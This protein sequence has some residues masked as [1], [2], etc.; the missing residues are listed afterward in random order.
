MLL[1]DTDD[2]PEVRLAVAKT[3][4]K[5]ISDELKQLLELTCGTSSGS[6]KVIST[7]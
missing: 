3:V 5:P 4:L 7:H 6:A 1:D 2:D